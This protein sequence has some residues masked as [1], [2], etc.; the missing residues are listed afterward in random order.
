MEL[1]FLNNRQKRTLVRW[2]KDPFLSDPEYRE[3]FRSPDRKFTLVVVSR[4]GS[5][6]FCWHVEHQKFTILELVFEGR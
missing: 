4:I 1:I 6:L 2:A 3:I 5:T